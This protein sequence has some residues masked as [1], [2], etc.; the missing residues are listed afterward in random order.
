MRWANLCFFA[1][2][3][4]SMC[5][6]VHCLLAWRG[7]AY[8]NAQNNCKFT[9]LLGNYAVALAAAAAAIEYLVFCFSSFFNLSFRP[10]TH[11]FFCFQ[12]RRGTCVRWA[13]SCFCLNFHCMSSSDQTIYAN[14][15]IS[16]GVGPA[17]PFGMAD[18][19][20]GGERRCPWRGQ[21]SI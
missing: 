1:F 20:G 10:T 14:W 2:Y 5:E 4:I 15:L 12:K 6:L 3:C 8:V 7:L 18:Q 9:I 11:C 16:Q 17:L 19:S 13:N 21:K